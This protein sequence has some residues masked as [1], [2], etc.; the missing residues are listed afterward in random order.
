[1]R[2]V[3]DNPAYEVVEKNDR[4]EVTFYAPSM[5]EAAEVSE[6]SPDETQT[7]IR[8]TLEKKEGKLYLVDAWVER[9]DKKRRVNLDEFET[10]LEYIE[11]TY[12]DE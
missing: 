12:A 1:M 8:L 9:G 10:W 11:E 6:A 4:V 2:F 5:A 7:V 3:R